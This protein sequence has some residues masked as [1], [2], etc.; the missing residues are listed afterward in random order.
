M[1]SSG[2]LIAALRKL[3]SE[4]LSNM[5]PHAWF[6]GFYYSHPTL[7]EPERTMLALK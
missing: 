5:T 2:P 4:N 7:V 6:S 3:A 1:K